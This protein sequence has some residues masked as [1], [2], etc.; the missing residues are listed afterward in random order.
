MSTGWTAPGSTA[1]DRGPAEGDDAA[2]MP[3]GGPEP[4]GSGPAAPGLGAA[5]VAGGT[6]RELDTVQP[7]FPLRPLGL[8][9]ILGA[10]VRIYRLR[11]RPALVLS[12]A[13]YGIAYVLITITTGVGM[14]P[15]IGEMQSVMADTTSTSTSATFGG[16]GEILSTV[17]STVVTSIITLVAASVVTVPLTR[18]AIDAATAGRGEDGAL[19]PTTRRFALP[20]VAVSLIVAVLTAVAFVVPTALGALPLLIVREA[21]IGTVGGLL[22]GLLLGVLASVW[23]WARLLL[24]V[25]SLAVEGT[26]VLGAVRRSFALT[27]GRRQWRVLGIGVL[28][29]ILYYLA[30]QVVA[31]V[32][33]TVGAVVYFAILLA[34]SFEAVVLGVTVLTVVSM[35]GAYLATFLLTPFYASAV[36]ALYADIRM[37]HEAWDVELV[38]ADRAHRAGAMA[39]AGGSG[40]AAGQVGSR[41]GGLLADGPSSGRDAGGLR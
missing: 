6:A 20:A 40:G 24:A 26:G 37:R 36:A 31:G 2:G 10:A 14:L 11:A 35:I 18:L 16:L 39:V 7:L 1:P 12:A 28:S 9:E 22:V 30:S 32:F 13:V 25:P 34:T 5:P 38:R 3:G 8:G 27:A 17:G 29:Y 4:L 23:V 41:S 21:G 33:G 15:L 19:W